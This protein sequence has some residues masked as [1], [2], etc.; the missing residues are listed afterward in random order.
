MSDR[1]HYTPG[2]AHGAQVQ[3]DGENWT[4]ILSSNSETIEENA[5]Q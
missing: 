3:K 1:E 5:K 2:P 4:L